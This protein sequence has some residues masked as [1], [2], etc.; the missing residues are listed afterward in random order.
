MISRFMTRLVSIVERRPS[1][2]WLGSAVSALGSFFAHNAAAAT[3]QSPLAT[4]PPV[5]ENLTAWMT[6][7]GAFFAIIGGFFTALIQIRN[8]FRK[9]KAKRR[10]K[11]QAPIQETNP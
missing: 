4:L 10:R 8:W 6:A 1:F 7:L 9:R 2:G 3:T 5:P 11:Q